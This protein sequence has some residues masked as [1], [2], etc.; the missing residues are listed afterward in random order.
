MDGGKVGV[1]KEGDEVCL[2]GFLEGHDGRGLETEI[3]LWRAESENGVQ[4][5]SSH[6]YVP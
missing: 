1:L 2:G 6:K 5:R 4:V 3:S